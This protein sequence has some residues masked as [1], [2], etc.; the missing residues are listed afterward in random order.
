MLARADFRVV[1]FYMF[2]FTTRAGSDTECCE[3]G[4]KESYV[5]TDEVLLINTK[6]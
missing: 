6:R 4:K 1:G 5:R 3:E 2:G